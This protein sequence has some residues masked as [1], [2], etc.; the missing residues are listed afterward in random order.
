MKEKLRIG[1][2][3]DIEVVH[4]TMKKL[5]YTY[6]QEN[7]F[8]VEVMSYISGVDLIKSQDISRL[9]VLFL[10]IEM[11]GLDGV[12][13]AYRLRQ[14]SNH[15]KIVML[16]GRVERFKE[17]FEIGAFRFVTKP[18]EEREVFKVMDA[19]RNCIMGNKKI[20]LKLNAQKC[21]IL[22]KDIMYVMI[23]KWA[24]CIC[25]ETYD[26]RDE[27]SLDWWE[28]KLDNRLFFRCHKSYIVNMSKI[29]E[30]GAKDVLLITGERIPVAKRR[31]KELE[32]HYMEYDAK[33]RWR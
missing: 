6:A 25:T 32:L 15:C 24:A 13:T 27:H 1:I 22:E 29:V 3:D 23:D 7:D 12:E 17:A 26:F 21:A 30:F 19:L 2:C 9:D 28:Q 4:D 18:I 5:I 31:M 11:P 14:I 16:T 10:D 8:T 33:Y 20:S